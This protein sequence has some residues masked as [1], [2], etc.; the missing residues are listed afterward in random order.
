MPPLAL[1]V[2]AGAAHLMAALDRKES[3]F[4]LA[5]FVHQHPVAWQW[6]RDRVA[7]LL[8]AHPLSSDA[9]EAVRTR[10]KKQKL[11]RL[12]KDLCQFKKSN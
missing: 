1:D 3:M 7:R 2:L 4:E 12:V 5:L 11:E 10:V 8:N 6:S 9:M